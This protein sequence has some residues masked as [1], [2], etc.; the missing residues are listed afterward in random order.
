MVQMTNTRS[1]FRTLDLKHL[2]KVMYQSSVNLPW[3]D[4]MQNERFGKG[5]DLRNNREFRHANRCLIVSS[6]RWRES[7]AFVIDSDRR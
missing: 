3:G 2:R 4:L 1:E 5:I 6:E 7:D